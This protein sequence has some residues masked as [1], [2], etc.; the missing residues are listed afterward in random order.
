[1]SKSMTKDALEGMAAIL[2]ENGYI[3]KETRIPYKEG[4]FNLI[5]TLDLNTLSRETCIFV[6]EEGL[7]DLKGGIYCCSR[8]LTIGF[9]EYLPKDYILKDVRILTNRDATKTADY[10]EELSK[11]T[12]V[13][14]VRDVF[15]GFF[16]DDEW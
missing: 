14:K 16:G 3:V 11:Y 4:K 8:N 13:C 10:E 2:R 7:E 6:N 9:I 12:H 1:M 15:N 5:E